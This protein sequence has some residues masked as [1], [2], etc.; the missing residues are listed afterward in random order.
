MTNMTGSKTIDRVCCLALAV[1]L[2][3]TALVWTGKAASGKKSAITVGYEG[4]F[5]TGV[6]HALDIEI[7]DWDGLIASAM[8]E[9]Y[10]ECAVTIDGERISNV[11]IRAK[12]NT[13]LSTV[14]SLGSTKYSF[15]I[16]FDQFVE[17]KTY[18]G[19]DKLSLNNLIYDATMMKDYLAYTLMNRAGVPSPLCSYV[20]ISV[21]GEPWGLYLAVEGVEDGFMERNNMTTGELYKPDSMSFGGGR[22]N[23]RDFDFEQFRVKDDESTETSETN[24]TPAAQ[25]E[26]T[27]NPFGTPPGGAN[28]RMPSGM[29]PPDGA[30]M[31]DSFQIPGSGNTPDGFQKPDGERVPDGFQMPD[32]PVT[33]GSQEGDS[34]P[35][36]GGGMF[37]FG[38]GSNDVKLQYIDDDPDSYSNIFNNAKTKVGKK[39]KV[40]LIEALRTLNS[41]NAQ[42]AVFTDEVIQYLA[43]HDFLQNDDSY[44]GMMVHN[45]YLYEEKGKLAIIPWDYNLAFGGMGGGSDA[46]STVNSPID[47]PVS[48]GTGSDRPLIAWIFSDEA[49]TAQYHETY[50]R[51]IADTVESGWLA[52][53]ISRVADLIRPYVEADANS[54]YSAEEFDTAVEALQSYCELRSKSVRGQL[55][56][57]IPSTSEGQRTDKSALVD[58]GTLSISDMGVMNTGGGGPGGD[59]A[60]SMPGGDMLSFGASGFPVPPSGFQAPGDSAGDDQK[61]ADQPQT[62][63]LSDGDSK[64]SFPDMQPQAGPQEMPESG[65]RGERGRDSSVS[66]TAWVT[67]GACLALLLAASFTIAKIRGHNS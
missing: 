34:R 43:V 36:R 30:G 53:E 27:G 5:D 38:M 46:S 41:E 12:G 64:P 15:K 40:R 25:T 21:N 51:F 58:A 52:S 13:S 1:M 23:G 45:Y 65:F 10:T 39:D 42:D 22:G 6:I 24:D 4:L 56:G 57:T 47:T 60:P 7:A 28:G 63:N 26:G 11:G 33:D 31:P 35:G 19:L 9:T 18:H 3:L 55:E 29:T 50:S 14:A 16:E 49:A 54:F 59:K 17:G 44:T 66:Q 2:A 20:Q 37:D 48:N 61:E 32:T 62:G 8:Q 67:F